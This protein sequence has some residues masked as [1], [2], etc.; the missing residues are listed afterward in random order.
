MI[1]LLDGCSM[2]TPAVYPKNWKTGGKE[3]L[4]FDWRVHYYFRDERF[5][6]KYPKGKYIVVKGM[7]AYHTLEER[8][9]A[10]RTL[11]ED[12]IIL[13]RDM[14]YNAITGIYYKEPEIENDYIIPPTMPVIQAFKKA[15]ERAEYEQATKTDMKNSLEY[16]YKS[17]RGLGYENKPISE[18]KR[19]HIRAILD[20]CANIKKKWT[21]NMFNS[22]RKYLSM[23]YSDQLVE[24]EAVDCNPI[25]D[26]KKKKTIKKIRLTLTQDE[27]IIVNTHLFNNHYEFW[28][29]AQ[30]FFHSGRRTTELFKVQ[31]KH[32]DLKNQRYT[33]IQKKGKEYKEVWCPIKNIALPHW[34]EICAKATP[35]DFIFAYDLKPG[36]KSIRPDQIS[37]RWK[38]HVKGVLDIKADFY[39]LK[40]SNADDIAKIYS[41]SAAQDFIGHSSEKM[42]RLYATG[43]ESR[44]LENMKK[45]SNSFVEPA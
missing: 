4:L 20:N 26:I 35:D 17:I 44:D 12:S 34:Q 21:E 22:Y 24:L 16:I 27:R 19:R 13:H 29:Y 43:Q 33:V 5:R 1:N 42:T 36:A 41:I 6:E 14:G 2:G 7:N 3:L 45:I 39:S 23:L 9:L 11:I 10:T 31:R 30:I 25:H 40:H 32:V 8:R 18:L 37:K 38:K 28:R 15:L